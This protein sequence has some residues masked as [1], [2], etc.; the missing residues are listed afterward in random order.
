LNHAG[1]LVVK[2]NKQK[3]VKNNFLKSRA[4]EKF[5][6]N[7]IVIDTENKSTSKGVFMKNSSK[8][9]VLS[10]FLISFFLFSSFVSATISPTTMTWVVPSSK[11]ILVSY[12][13][14]CSATAFFFVETNATEDNDT[15]GNAARILPYNLRSGG[16]ACQAQT[17]AP[18]VITNNGNATTN[19]DVNFND[20][21]DTNIWLKVWMGNGDAATDCG[22]ADAFGGYSKLCALPGAADTTTPVAYTTCRDFNSSNETT[23]VRLISSLPVLDTNHLCVS[24]ELMGPVITLP[25]NVLA[26]DHNGTFNTMTD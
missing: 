2:K 16:S 14:S 19:I 20:N 6:N 8:I 15:D 9:L 18:I 7:K 5:I 12:G 25:S 24:G 4:R 1:K 21:I 22:A 11:S 3:P 26:G 13:G 23:T 17:T 10:V